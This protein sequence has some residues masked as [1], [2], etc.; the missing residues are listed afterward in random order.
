MF[1]FIKDI[2][3]DA[4]WNYKHP[5]LRF[6]TSDR[7]MELDVWVPSEQLA[8]EYQGEQHFFPVKFFGGANKFKKTQAR[9]IE[10][11]ETCM[12]KGI[13]LIAVPY[14]WDGSKDALYSMINEAI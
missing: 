9:D 4:E 7:K 2:F 3:P 1:R 10:K 11:L 12:R 5:D 13:N 8:L 14:T 6:A